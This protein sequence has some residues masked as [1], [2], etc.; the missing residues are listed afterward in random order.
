MF[1]LCQRAEGRSDALSPAYSWNWQEATLFQTASFNPVWRSKNRQKKKKS[2]EKRLMVRL[3]S[4]RAL[5]IQ[6]IKCCFSVSSLQKWFAPI[7]FFCK[8]LCCRGVWFCSCMCLCQ[9][10]EDEEQESFWKQATFPSLLCLS[11]SRLIVSL[12]WFFS[13]PSLMGDWST[14]SC[15]IF[16]LFFFLLL[17]RRDIFLWCWCCFLCSAMAA[18][19]SAFCCPVWVFKGVE[20]KESSKDLNFF[21]K[22]TWRLDTR[23]VVRKKRSARLGFFQLFGEN[24]CAFFKYRHKFEMQ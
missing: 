12:I 24:F 2:S 6:F 8:I 1:T 11:C 22:A 23:G 15:F 10:G 14:C 3:S 17:F 19:H 16:C 13:L 18:L 7:S 5:N 20:I 4:Q 9:V 21:F